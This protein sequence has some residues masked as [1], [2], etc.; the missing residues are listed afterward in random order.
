MQ[1][2]SPKKHNIV[3]NEIP[4]TDL[5]GGEEAVGIFY[6]RILL[7][8]PRRYQNYRFRNDKHPFMVKPFDIAYFDITKI[9]T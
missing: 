3:F 2:K 7:L 6:V 8:Q 5:C 4:A 9:R 1:H